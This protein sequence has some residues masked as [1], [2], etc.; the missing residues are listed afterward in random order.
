MSVLFPAA[1]IILP[2]E[3]LQTCTPELWVSLC[4]LVLPFPLQMS[5]PYL[6]ARCQV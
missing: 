1:S 5:I 4:V 3:F 6:E 2:W